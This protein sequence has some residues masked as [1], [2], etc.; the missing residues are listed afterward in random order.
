MAVIAEGQITLA[1][2]ES[3]R[4]VSAYKRT[5]DSTTPTTPTST[6]SFP[7]GWTAA[8][9]GVNKDYPYEFVSQS[10]LIGD[11]YGTWSTP[12]VCAVYTAVQTVSI[13]KL[14]ST[15]T[16]PATPTGGGTSI[17]SGWSATI[18]QFTTSNPYVF[19]SQTTL[20]GNTYGNWSAPVLYTYD[21][22]NDDAMFAV[23]TDSGNKVGIFSSGT[24][25]GSTKLFVNADYIR[26]GKLVVKDA[27]ENIIFQA[28][29]DN[30]STNLAGWIAAHGRFYSGSGSSYVELNS[31]SSDPHAIMAGG[32]TSANARFLL[33]KDGSLTLKDSNG[34][35]ALFFDSDK[36][37]F[38]FNGV[39]G[40]GATYTD[41]LY[42]EQGNV[43]DI[44]V[45][46]LDT[47]DYIARYL[48]RN[49]ADLNHVRITSDSSGLPHIYLLASAVKR[50]YASGTGRERLTNS[51]GTELYWTDELMTATTTSATAYPAYIGVT[52]LKNPYNESMYWS[53]NISGATITDGYPYIN[54]V[55]VYTTGT[56]TGYPVK[57]WDY[58]DQNKADLTFVLNTSNG[59]YEPRL[60]LGA[61]DQNGTAR[62]YIYK[63]A[64]GLDIVYDRGNAAG[65]LALR[66]NESGNVQKSLTSNGTTIQG[67]IAGMLIFE[68]LTVSESSWS[69]EATPTFTSYPYAAQLTCQGATSAM[70][71]EVIFSPD[72][73][74]SGKLATAAQSG[75]N[76]VTIYAS[77]PI[78]VTVLRIELRF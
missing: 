13:Y 61:G 75:T 5:A 12:A 69:E 15:N 2:V 32:S 53:Q 6:D 11:T 54:G 68:N 41:S 35:R 45:S 31:D 25:S 51:S 50:Y 28:D 14:T 64:N 43:A 37:S 65:E 72:D 1:K 57:V 18:P 66:L 29:I 40:S 77:E 58:D 73:V 33:G 21:P 4:T 67:A 59:Y 56:N 63:G 22:T 48:T 20:E 36:R 74:G 34:D 60:V 49:I 16:A 7:T 44:T 52:T 46:R 70:G 47:G 10:L 9:S 3:G 23:L 17:P 8:P 19:I 62:G 71:G 30:N 39:L 76:R 27:Q 78:D 26:A 55:R 24:V 38:V 42:A